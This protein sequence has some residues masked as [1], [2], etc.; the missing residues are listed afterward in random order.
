[1]AVDVNADGKVDLLT[2]GAG[3]LLG[4]GGGTF[5][6]PEGTD[7]GAG[8]G[9]FAVGD[10]NGDGRPDAASATSNPHQIS[11]LFNDGIWFASGDAP[12][13]AI[14]DVMIG[15]GNV[16]TTVATFTVSLSAASSQTV[17][18]QYAAGDASASAAGGDYQAASGTLTFAPGVTSQ[19]IAV[20]VNGDRLGESAESFAVYLSNSTNAYIADATGQGKILD[21]EPSIDIVGYSGVEGNTGT[22]AFT[23]IVALST[24]YDVP[25]TVDHATADDDW[26]GP[27]ATAGVDYVPS[28]GTLTFAPGQTSMSIAVQVAGDRLW[29]GDETFLVHLSNTNHGSLGSSEA[30][31]YIVD[32]EPSVSIN[33]YVSV[34]E[35]NTGTTDATFTVTLSTASDVPVTVNFATPNSTNNTAMAGSDYVAASGTLSFAPGQTS[36]PISILVNGDL[37]AESVEYFL[38]SLTAATNAGISNHLGQVTIVDDDAPLAISIGDVSKAEGKKGQTTLFTFTVTLSAACNQPVTMSYRTVNGTA[39]TG[40]GDYVA[41]TG[42]MTFAPGQTTKTITIEVKGDSKK[43]ANEA[44]YLD[45]FGLSSNALFTKSRGIGTIVN[46]D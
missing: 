41:K 39:T 11:V 40:N 6:L 31:G 5:K 3:V 2:A 34:V 35:G 15:E 33:G 4:T 42:T 7:T 17:S 22:T 14:D 46:D 29:E 20:L 21:D 45:L 16:G 30:Q 27:S 18:V 26:I 9:S 8:L 37:L 12:A 44:F 38:V 32:D 13:L 25:V 24:A 43:E 10:F 19:T 23:F 28:S 36:L 1:V